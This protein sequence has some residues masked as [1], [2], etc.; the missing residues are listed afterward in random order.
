MN[1]NLKVDHHHT[2]L[3]IM[4]NSII[5]LTTCQI[6]PSK[7]LQIEAIKQ[8]IKATKQIIKTIKCNN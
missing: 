1:C 7:T 6:I 4:I 3:L 5:A 2:I 8:I